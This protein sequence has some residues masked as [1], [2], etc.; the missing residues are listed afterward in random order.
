MKMTRRKALRLGTAAMASASVTGM[1]TH[2]VAKPPD[3][4][5]DGVQALVNEI[6]GPGLE[7]SQL[8]SYC[9]LQEVA[10][11][12]ETLPGIESIRNDAWEEKWKERVGAD[13]IRGLEWHLTKLCQPLG[14]ADT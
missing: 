2:A 10:D 1:G 4:L 12:L 13:D 3:P 11:L 14:R 7:G 9:A 8:I 6:R 5:R